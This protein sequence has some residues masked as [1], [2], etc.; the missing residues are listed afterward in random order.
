MNQPPEGSYQPQQPQMQQEHMSQQSPFAQYPPMQPPYQQQASQMP[1]QQQAPQSPYQQVFHPPYQQQTPQPPYQQAPQPPYQQV[2]QPPYQQAPQM[3]YPPYQ[4]P[5][6]MTQ[7]VN[8]N[9]GNVQ[10]HGFLTR[11]LYFCFIGW[12]L[13][14]FWLQIGYAL[15][16]FI[17]T[18][19]LGL[20][21][22]NR[23]PMVMT[24]RPSSD[25][26]TSVNV[27]T[28]MVQGPNGPMMM[29]NV[30]VNVGGVQQRSFLLRALYFIFVGWYAGYIWACIGYA[31][32]V[33]IVLLPVGLIMLNRLPAVLTLRKN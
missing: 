12:W 25:T 8:V 19:P 3:P 2:P 29:Q 5:S 9:V 18:L 33:S 17:V 30:N 28:S 21:M 26:G 20:V 11:A 14:F 24:L 16:V 6:M 13:G 27:S 31:C 7:N 22:L 15:C 23:L 1:Y 32:V 10:K 4:Q